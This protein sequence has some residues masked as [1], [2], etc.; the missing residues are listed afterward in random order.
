MVKVCPVC[1]A[2]TG[3]DQPQGAPGTT[4]RCPTC[5]GHWWEDATP[6]WYRHGVAVCAALVGGIVLLALLVVPWWAVLA[7]AV[8]LVSAVGGFVWSWGRGAR[9]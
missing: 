4:Y 7:A 6:W 2:E 3:Q 1:C 5:G 9:R 8:L